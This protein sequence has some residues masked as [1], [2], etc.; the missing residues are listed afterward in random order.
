MKAD[1]RYQFFRNL[2]LGLHVMW[3]VLSGLILAM[4]LLGL[5]VGRLEGW[6]LGD[7]IYFAFVTGL[8]IGY[9]DFLPT[10]FAARVLAVAIGFCGVLLT[11]LVAAV[12]VQALQQAWRD[13]H[14]APPPGR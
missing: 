11:G 9:G 5:A 10:T 6:H 4:A 14:P 13:M 2:L 1:L 7:G 8:T 12:G 3:P